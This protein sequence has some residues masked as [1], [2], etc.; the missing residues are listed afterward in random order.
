MRA[1]LYNAVPIEAVE[2]LREFH[3]R[4]RANGMAE[5]GHSQCAWL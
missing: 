2:A 1:S 5:S 4:F 3:A